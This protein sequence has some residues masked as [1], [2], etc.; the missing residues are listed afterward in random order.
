MFPRASVKCPAPAS[1]GSG[2]PVPARRD[3]RQPDLHPEPWPR[4][5]AWKCSGWSMPRASS[6]SAAGVTLNATDAAELAETL[7][8]LADWLQRDPGRLGALLEDFGGHPAC[9]SSCGRF[10]LTPLRELSWVSQ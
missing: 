1:R 8:F 9:N 4:P 2:T 5:A 10:T 7:Q 3:R 6:R